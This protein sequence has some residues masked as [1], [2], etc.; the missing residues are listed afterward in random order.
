[1]G[2][3]GKGPSGCRC[4]SRAR[5]SDDRSR[6]FQCP[7][8]EEHGCDNNQHPGDPE[9][10]WDLLLQLDPYKFMELDGINPRIF[11]GLADA[12]AKPLSM[13]F[14]KPWESGEVPAQWKLANIVPIFKKAK[15]EDPRN[16]KP[17]H[18]TSVPGKTM[19]KIIMRYIEKHMEKNT[20]IGHSQHSFMREKSS[21]SNP[22]SFND[23]VDT[24]DPAYKSG[25]EAGL[26]RVLQY[27]KDI[28][29][30]QKLDKG[31]KFA[32]NIIHGY[33]RYYILKVNKVLDVLK[34]KFHQDNWNQR[35]PVLTKKLDID[36]GYI[37]FALQ[38]AN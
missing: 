26:R 21:L 31:M 10:V 14:D 22:I 11:N 13:I 35:K 36:S 6:G 8:L 33:K 27:T 18:L 3:A 32:K 5:A 19:Q 12:I 34:L 29:K 23:K 17:V 15:K 37:Y 1:M 2:A 16:Y 9:L 4:P 30:S 20:V 28:S 7:E 24:Y 25:P 38:L